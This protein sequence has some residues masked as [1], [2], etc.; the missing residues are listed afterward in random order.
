MR[1]MRHSSIASIESSS[2]REHILAFN[3]A[4]SSVLPEA[5][6]IL[7]GSRARGDATEESDFDF[8]IITP[9]TLE[10]L[11]RDKLNEAMYRVE[12]ERGIVA[13]TIVCSREEWNG[14]LWRAAP[15]RA[16]IEREGIA[17]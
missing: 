11:V 5:E 10:P 17:V 12:L 2:D 9:L 14:M 8:L 4:V 1:S 7:F 6:V 3:D 13:T 16:N 15:L